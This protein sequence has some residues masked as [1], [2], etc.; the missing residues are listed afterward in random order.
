MQMKTKTIILSLIQE[1]IIFKLKLNL[2][3]Y[4]RITI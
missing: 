1:L 2:K 3:E 4:L